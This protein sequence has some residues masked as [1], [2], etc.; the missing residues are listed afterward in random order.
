VSYRLAPKERPRSALVRA[1]A[2]YSSEVQSLIQRGET[3]LAEAKRLRTPVDPHTAKYQPLTVA[4][5]GAALGSRYFAGSPPATGD[6]LADVSRFV[7][8]Q[9]PAYSQM[10]YPEPVRSLKTEQAAIEQSL[11]MLR[12]IAEGSIAPKPST[13]GEGA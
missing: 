7:T 10:V 12:E 13:P 5:R 8:R 6:W 3:L 1:A 4:A 9:V 11:A 2:G